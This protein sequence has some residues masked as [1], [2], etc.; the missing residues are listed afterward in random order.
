MANRL[1]LSR[2]EIAMLSAC[3]DHALHDATRARMRLRPGSRLIPAADTTIRELS[4]LRRKFPAV[5]D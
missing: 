3:L 1:D 4:A 5:D 2:E